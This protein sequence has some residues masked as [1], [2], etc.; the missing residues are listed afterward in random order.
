MKTKLMKK[1][2]IPV[3]KFASRAELQVKKYSPEILLGLGIAGIV[4]TCV[5][6]CRVTLKSKPMI[7]EYKE[8]VTNLKAYWAEEENVK[9]ETS[10]YGRDLTI[11]TAKTVLDVGV[12][13]APAALLGGL[14]VACLVGGHKIQANR[15]AALTTA[16]NAVQTAFT[17][18]RE[19]IREEYGEEKDR[20][21]YFGTRKMTVTDETTDENGKVKKTKKVV[22]G[23]TGKETHSVYGRYFDESSKFWQKDAEYN[24]LFLKA[25]QN[26]MNDRLDERGHVFLNEV[27]D[28]LGIPRTKA[29]AVV[30]WVK[31]AGDGYI[32]F[33]IYDILNFKSR[34]FVNGY[35]RSIFLDFN[36][37]GLIYDLI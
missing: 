7:D 19:R 12:K 33:G 16:Y 32:D 9:E 21:A 17:G 18:Y 14:S 6:S 8:A 2:T 26:Q 15:L 28:A 20:E 27:Y 35:E 29:G 10:S 24:L 11:L 30:G 1:V 25:V 31:S 37:D 36:V 34:D 5:L 23:T 22:D 13:Y 4:G 3:L